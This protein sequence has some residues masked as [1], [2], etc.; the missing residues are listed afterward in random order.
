MISNNINKFLRTA[1]ILTIP[2]RFYHWRHLIQVSPR[3]NLS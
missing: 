2:S 3:M 1:F